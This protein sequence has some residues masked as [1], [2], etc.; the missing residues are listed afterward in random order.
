MFVFSSIVLLIGC[1]LMAASSPTS[2]IP[3][4]KM[5]SSCQDLK[6]IGHVLS[7]FYSVK[8]QVQLKGVLQSVYCDFTKQ[9]KEAGTKLL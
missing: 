7:G 9:E 1:M 6:N 3:A 4:T 2:V 5:P 8:G